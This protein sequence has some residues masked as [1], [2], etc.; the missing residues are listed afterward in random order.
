MNHQVLAENTP[1]GTNIYRL[2]GVDPE[3]SPV[4][5]GISGTNKLQVDTLTGIVSVARNIDREVTNMSLT[6]VG[7]CLVRV[8]SHDRFYGGGNSSQA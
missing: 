6:W 8:F 2:K 3:G 5:Y 7:F 1:I 4:K